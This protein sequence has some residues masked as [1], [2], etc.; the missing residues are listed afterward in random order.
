MSLLN[1]VSLLMTPNAIKESKVYSIIPSNGN[2]DLD[3]TRA[4]TATLTNDAGFIENV[5]YNLLTYSEQFNDISWT[6]TAST[7]TPN[8]TNAPNGTL[9]ADTFSGDGLSAGHL[10]GSTISTIYTIGTTY[11]F[12]CYVKKN[13]NNFIQLTLGSAAF[14]TNSYANFD[15]NNGTLGTVAS[16][17]VA[18][19]S[20][21][22]NGWYRCAISITAT[23]TANTSLNLV[24]IQ[25]ATSVRVEVNT[26][27]TSVYLWGAQLVQGSIPKDYFYTTDRLNVPRLNYDSVGGCPSLLLEPQR[28]NLVLQSEDFN[29]VAW[30]KSNAPTITTNIAVSPNGTTTADGIKADD[31]LNYKTISQTKTVSANST[32]TFSIFVK[33]VVSET[34]YGGFSVQFIGGTSKVCYGIVNAVNGTIT[35]VSS[36]IT[37]ITSVVSFG[38]YWRICCTATDNGSNTSVK[39]DYYATL[40]Q[41]GTT[42]N[43]GTGSV[44][45]I[46]GAQLE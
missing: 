43:T 39:I 46:W 15:L 42:L 21:A 13:T 25:S 35:I 34:F 27:N 37:P 29:D 41:N 33:K 31:G 16:G 18:T 22:D 20:N 36:T 30:T 2:G 19:I 3:F 12:S 4:T 44:R 23:A 8:S 32:L 9:T 10:I 45:T 17:V 28:T 26:L 5:P 38:D 6:K 40:S 1:K 24:L 11:T 14:G 7:I